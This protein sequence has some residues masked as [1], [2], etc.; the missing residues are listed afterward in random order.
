MADSEGKA[1]KNELMTRAGD[2]DLAPAA[3][4][5]APEIAR[6]GRGRFAKTNPSE[7]G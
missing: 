7:V 1:I 3:I 5:P 4:A 2:G 6:I